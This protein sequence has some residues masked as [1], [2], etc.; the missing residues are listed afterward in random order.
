MVRLVGA[1]RDHRKACKA[2]QALAEKFEHT[3]PAE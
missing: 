1:C 3:G 2:A